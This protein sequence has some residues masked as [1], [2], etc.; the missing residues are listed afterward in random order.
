MKRRGAIMVLTLL[1]LTGLVAI[2]VGATAASRMAFK[3]GLNR[4]EERRTDIAADAAC[5]YVIATLA[6]QSKTAI[7]PTDDWVTLGTAGDERFTYGNET[8]RIQVLDAA[9]RINLNTVGQAQLQQ[10]NFT[11]DQI[12]SLLD[13]RSAGQTARANGAKDAYYNGLSQPYNTSLR[14]FKTVDELLLVKGFT[15]QDLMKTLDQQEAVGGNSSTTNTT[16]TTS[17]A[18]G[19]PTPILYDLLTV[20]SVSNDV[21]ANGQPKLGVN[22]GA[23][24]MQALLRIGLPPNLAGAI[25][26]RRVTGR[27]FTTLGQLL[28]LPGVNTRTA[29]LMLNSLSITGTARVTGKLD[30]NT[31]TADVL[32]T[33][34]NIT[35]DQVQAITQQ[36]Q[37]GF[38]SLGQIASIGI[39]N[40]D[41]QNLVDLFSVNT[42]SFLV[43]IVAQAGGTKKAYEATISIEGTTPKVLRM[44]DA[45]LDA[46]TRWGWA[47]D[48]STD[49][50]ITGG[51]ATS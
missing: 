8:F 21:G 14:P 50:P 28:A 49:T 45:P 2:L 13:W 31:V 16:T 41:L 44:T 30:L 38:T 35:A 51:T 19:A 9:S 23:A 33:L 17:S 46:T 18:T 11:T 7:T 22:S 40:R 6:T 26:Q 32:N 27:P 10:M 39:S 20:D 29:T 36:Q 34:P 3:A 4:M 42:Q 24:N 5:Q 25:V 12:D 1:V 15:A 37:T 48:A 43:R 47:D